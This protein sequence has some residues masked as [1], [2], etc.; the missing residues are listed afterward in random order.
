MHGGKCGLDIGTM[1]FC[2]DIT[3]P[4]NNRKLLD[5]LL[6]VELNDRISDKHHMDM[7]KYL[8]KELYDMNSRVVNLNETKS[9]Q[10]LANIYYTINT[11]IPF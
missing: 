6:R 4:Y 9:R 1:K 3:I 10:K 8:N 2:F 7:K 11:H 5:M